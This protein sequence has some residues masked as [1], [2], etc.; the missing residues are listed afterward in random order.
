MRTLFCDLETYSN[1]DI[2]NGTYAYC[3]DVEVLLF[4]Y[5]VDG[6]P[7]KVWDLTLDETMPDDLREGLNDPSVRLVWH[8]GAS[9]DRTVLMHAKNLRVEI[10]IERIDDTMAIAYSHG[11]VGSLGGLCDIYKIAQDKAK[12]TRGRLLIQKFCKL[13]HGKRRTRETDPADWAHFKEYARLDVEA[14]REIWKKLPRWNWRAYDRELFALDRRINDRG[15]LID[16]ELAQACV[17]LAKTIRGKN[18]T[19]TSELTRGK[20]ISANQREALLSYL[21]GT[22]GVGLKDMRSSTIESILAKEELPPVASELLA[23]RL[24]SAKAS[25]SKYKKLIAAMSSDHRLRGCLQFRGASRTGRWCLTGDHE[26]LTPDGWVRLDEWDG[27]SIAVWSKSGDL[28]SFQASQPLVFDYEGPM[29]AWNTTRFAQVC[30]PDHK[31]PYL[32]NGTWADGTAEEVAKKRFAIPFTGTRY[33]TTSNDHIKVRVL[34]MVQADGH[35]AKEGFLRL[36]L[37]KTRKIERCR[38]LLRRAGLVFSERVSSEGGTTFTVLARHLPMWLRLFKGKQYGWWMLDESPE[39]I[40]DE[41]PHWAGYVSGP[42]SIRY[43]TTVKENADIVQAC[44]CLSGRTATILKRENHEKNQADTYVVNIWLTPSPAAKI[45]EKPTIVDYKGK[46]YC[47]KT[48]TGYFLVRRNGRVWVTGNSGKV[49]QP[50]N[51]P[52]PTLKQ[53][54]IDLGIPALKEGW[55]DIVAEPNELMSSCLR[56]V[57]CAPK[58]EHL[59]VADLSNIEGRVLAWLAGEKWKLDAFRLADEGKGQDLYKLTY[60]RTFGV[61]PAEVTKQQRQIGKVEELALGYRGGVGAFLTFATAYGVDLDELAQHVRGA[62]A[63]ELWR[64][65]EAAYPWFV[66]KKATHGLSQETFIALDAIKRGWRQSHSA[67]SAF[68]LKLE[69][70]CVRALA[71]ETVKIGRLVLDRRGV[72]LRIRLPS[73]RYLCYPRAEDIRETKDMGVISFYG[74]DQISRKWKRITT[75]GGKLAENVT[76]AVALDVLA[77]ALLRAENEGLRVV[78]SVHDEIIAEAPL[79]KTEKDLVRV[80]TTTPTWGAGLPLNAAGFT[81]DRYRKD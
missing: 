24:S 15:M 13:Y 5:A 66:E 16:A 27:G 8:N 63:D 18:D 12:D 7:A 36:H 69:E 31:V 78:L 19:R 4:A 39:V 64:E 28:I 40:F 14:M 33:V 77:E 61:N 81:A 9:F 46:V 57:I 71:G 58:G 26:V 47:A 48:P 54:V 80:M 37:K 42:N 30:T 20:L 75:H 25:V 10:P 3:E 32:K 68:W 22:Y 45:R 34:I 23:V 76:Q 1:I 41:L 72:W 79:E 73:G 52:R 51:L 6:E 38:H 44:A 2:H 29:Y 50:Q 49:Y 17:D 35:F 59:V 67:I 11:L 55:S 62:I 65:A 53:W 70:G 56:S 21:N 74:V 43:C 60:G